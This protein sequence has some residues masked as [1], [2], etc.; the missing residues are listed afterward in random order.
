MRQSSLSLWD[1]VTHADRD[2]AIARVERLRQAHP[3]A[4][5]DALHK[6]LVR[7][8]CLQAGAVGALSALTGAIPGIGRIA[9]F[10]LGPL[11][12][13]ALVSVLQAELVLETFTLY[14]F[15]L[16]AGAEKMAVLGIAAT[17]IG[18]DEIAKRTGQV[19]AETLG[20]GLAARL[21]I[22]AW[23]LAKI[24]TAAATNIAVTYA[25]GSRAQKLCKMR[26]T[27][28]KQWPQLMRSAV[29]IP[30]T[31]LT[32][33]ATRSARTALDQNFDMLRS[34]RERMTQLAPTAELPL[35]PQMATAS[36]RKA[37]AA[38]PVAATR[39]AAARRGT[40][41]SATNPVVAKKAPAKQRKPR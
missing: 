40:P 31:Q 3:K 11:A 19:I 29:M 17:N 14:E 33:W 32:D 13:A 7:S 25:I 24:G 4:G 39:K 16:P 41:K 36:S 5:R 21:L 2:A 12:D 28:L 1:A 35:L 8:K 18:A 30:P 10:A 34:W 20:K 6:M 15:E 9:S 27:S 26:E 37:R 22:K 38:P 23:P